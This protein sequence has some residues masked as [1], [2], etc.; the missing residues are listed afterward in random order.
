ML[1]YIDEQLAA[2]NFNMPAASLPYKLLE[3]VMNVYAHTAGMWSLYVV[4]G[5]LGDM[6]LSKI[7]AFS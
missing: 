4:A 6:G 3:A 1:F 5:M 7:Y 2:H